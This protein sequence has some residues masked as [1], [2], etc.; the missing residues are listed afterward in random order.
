MLA[1]FLVGIEILFQY[2]RHEEKPDDGKK[3]K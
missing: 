1:A 3:N 2:I